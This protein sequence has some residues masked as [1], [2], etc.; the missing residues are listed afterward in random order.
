MNTKRGQVQIEV[1]YRGASHGLTEPDIDRLAHL[2]RMFLAWLSGPSVLEIAQARSIDRFS[3]G[4][5]LGVSFHAGSTRSGH[6]VPAPGRTSL[7]E[8]CRPGLPPIRVLSH[9]WGVTLLSILRRSIRQRS[10]ARGFAVLVAIA[11]ILATM[12]RSETHSHVVEDHAHVRA[13]LHAAHHAEEVRTPSD[14]PAPSDA[15]EWTTPHTHQ[16]A[17]FAVALLMIEPLDVV[18]LPPES[19]AA[20]HRG[21]TVDCSPGAPPH[22][23]PIA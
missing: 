23:P 17:A 13:E 1:E 8:R 18:A 7:N 9:A 22:R 2:V 14:A 6:C 5:D 3:I 11:L 21:R 19:W 15:Q 10:S 12:P 20:I 4:R 16:I